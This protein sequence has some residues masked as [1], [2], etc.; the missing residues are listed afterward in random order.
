MTD[1]MNHPV[2]LLMFVRCF[3]IAFDRVCKVCMSTILKRLDATTKKHAT[4]AKPCDVCESSYEAKK[5]RPKSVVKC[6]CANCEKGLTQ[7][8]SIVFKPV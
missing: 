4:N 7:V 5:F 8:A 3:A 1:I 6:P 2:D